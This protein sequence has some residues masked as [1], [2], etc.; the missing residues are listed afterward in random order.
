MAIIFSAPHA[1]TQIE[2]SLLKERIALSDYQI[3]KASDPYTDSLDIFTCA[4]KKHIANT[5]RLICDFNRAP[6][7]RYAFREKDF[8]GNNIF[9]KNQLWTQQ[10]KE[11][12]LEKYWKV[13]HNEI[14]QSIEE[15]DAKGENV[16]LLVDY[17]NTSGDHPINERKDYMPS[18][19][20]SNL[21]RHIDG[22]TDKNHPILS[23]PSKYMNILENQIKKELP[24]SVEVNGVYSGGF[25][26]QWF[27]HL[28]GKVSPKAKLFAVQIEYNL[29]FIV[30]PL[31]K[32]IDLEALE[33]L[34]KGLNTALTLMHQHLKEDF[35]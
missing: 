25:E 26:V 27:R 21:G 10:E 11:S 8:F 24:L 20:I 13:Y 23:L 4:D 2:D 3:W 33:I 16:I 12:F 30:N 34:Q 29:N 28:S 7:I 1:Q 35:V 9:V 15:L 22:K 18:I 6:D 32:K 31:T 19:V 14:I 17:H 5:H